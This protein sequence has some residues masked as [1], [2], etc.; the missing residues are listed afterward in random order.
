MAS[1]STKPSAGDFSFK[2]HI[3]FPSCLIFTL[4]LLGAY[5]VFML[6]DFNVTETRDTVTHFYNGQVNDGDPN[7]YK[8]AVGDQFA[9][10]LTQL[11]GIFLFSVSVAALGLLDRY[12]Y[13]K[14]F[15]RML[16]FGGTIFALFFFVLVI[17]GSVSNIGFG[18]SMLVVILASVLYFVLLG[19]K[20]LF[21]K[22]I[23][24]E[25]LP[26]RSYVYK[27]AMLTFAVFTAT[28]FVC[29][30]LAKLNFFNVQI[31]LPSTVIE[32][33]DGRSKT[34]IYD[35][36]ITPLAPTLQN[37]LRYLASAAV[38]SVALSVLYTKLH[39]V[40]KAV[41]N[42]VITAC[43]FVLLWLIQMEFFK[44]LD[45]TM[46]YAIISFVS[47]YVAVLVTVSIITFVKRRKA[48]DEEEYENQFLPGK[49]S[50]KKTAPDQEG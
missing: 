16:H 50:K 41:I 1:S 4:I 17:G 35:T 10:D 15:T 36:L 40:L 5:T 26:F 3:L 42:F 47:I 30:L 46:L 23:K 38:F 14:L 19:L 44:E 9:L 49:K 12:G 18:S 7:S 13:G 24:P 31:N 48:E 8:F 28:V 37:Y 2:R 6:L 11:I 25:K 20:T 29:M 22:L 27:Y 34:T 39:A 33:D 21:K 32:S 45:N 43:G